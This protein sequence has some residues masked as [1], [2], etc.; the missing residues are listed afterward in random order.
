MC[1]IPPSPGVVQWVTQGLTKVLPQPDDKYKET[2]EA[3]KEEHTEV[4]HKTEQTTMKVQVYGVGNAPKAENLWVYVE[5]RL[6]FCS[7]FQP[8]AVQSVK[9]A[10][11]I[12]MVTAAFTPPW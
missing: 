11:K 6:R 1:A 12:N 10:S 2:K 9:E 7:F 4:R 3:E 5:N 8:S